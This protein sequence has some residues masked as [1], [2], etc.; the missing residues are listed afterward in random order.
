MSKYMFL[1]PVDVW[2]FRDGKP[3]SAGGDH[4]AESLFPPYPTVIQGA[5]RSKQ[6]ARKKMLLA[7]KASIAK[8]VGT[9]SDYQNLRL[10]GPFLAKRERE[11]HQERIFRYLPQPDDAITVSKEDHTIRRVNL[12]KEPPDGIKT[13]KITPLLLGLDEEPEKGESG[14]WIRED[15]LEKY[16]RGETIQAIPGKFLFERDDRMGVGID[17]T[18]MKSI[19]GMLYEVS[20][21]RPQKDVGLL[22]EFSGYDDWPDKDILQLGGESRGSI[23]EFIDPGKIGLDPEQN[24]SRILEQPVPSPLPQKFLL[25]FCTPTFFNNGW[26][27]NTWSDFFTEEVDL[28]A[29]AVGRYE[30]IGGFD[31]T[32]D[33]QKFGMNKAAR[34]FVP[35]G[36]VYYFEWKKTTNIKPNLIQNAISDFAR[37]IGFGQ[38]I[39]K[40]W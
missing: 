37:E 17:S 32:E 9:S 5:I 7:D 31:M 38:I 23:Y 1:Q 30:S 35:A 2:L 27:P 11:D 22:V 24:I 12:P 40:E 18:A 25:Y 28:V 16:F 34:R 3:F 33:S 20:F 29:A 19:D 8:E 39:V 14:L 36:S 4:R 6:L 15:K 26:Q 21:I 10:K 13:S